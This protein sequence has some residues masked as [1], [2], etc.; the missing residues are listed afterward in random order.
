MFSTSFPVENQHCS[1]PTPGLPFPSTWSSANGLIQVRQKTQVAESDPNFHLATKRVKFTFF[2]HG[3]QSKKNG[4]TNIKRYQIVSKRIKIKKS[5]QNVSMTYELPPLF[6]LL[7][8]GVFFG[9]RSHESEHLLE[10][11]RVRVVEGMKEIH[12]PFQFLRDWGFQQPKPTE[13]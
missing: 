7:L 11:S 6:F 2:S 13:W 9:E 3:K 5:N 12:H 4:S 1:C 8:L 10:H